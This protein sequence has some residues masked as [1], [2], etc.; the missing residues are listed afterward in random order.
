MLVAVNPYHL[1]PIYGAEHINLYDQETDVTNLPPHIF[2]TAHHAFISM[3]R[4]LQNQSII[5]R[6]DIINIHIS[7]LVIWPQFHRR[8]ILEVLNGLIE[9]E[10]CWKHFGDFS[11]RPELPVCGTFLSLIFFFRFHSG[12]SG[13]GKTESTKL[14]LRYLTVVS[15]QHTTLDQQILDANPILEGMQFTRFKFSLITLFNWSFTS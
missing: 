5:I 15:G 14:I 6:Y 12:E 9:A 1:Y 7:S 4:R 10:W 11:T 8:P 3:K 2:S 13:A